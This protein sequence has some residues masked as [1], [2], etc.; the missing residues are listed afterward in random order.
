M[1]VPNLRGLDEAIEADAKEIAI[2]GSATE[3]FSHR[4]INCSIAESL[5]KFKPIV[6]RAIKEGIK[7][8]GYIS[9]VLGCPVEGEVLPEKVGDVAKALMDMGCYE[10]SL[11]DTIGIGTPTKVQRLLDI[12]LKDI[13]VN[14]IAGHFHDTYGQALANILTSL[15]Y[16]VSTFDCSVAGLGGCPFAGKG[17]SGNVATE[18]VLFMLNGMNIETGIDIN[19]LV[20]VG[21]FI[22][23]ELEKPSA[24]KAGRALL[25][26][27]KVKTNRISNHG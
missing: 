21:E 5:Q 26:L 10:I 17:A 7:I 16:G 2:F 6:D 13:Q 25:S 14:Q 12:M 3:G 22:C 23:N 24:S 20:A 19:K 11:G 27:S 8:R 4:N 1:L 9:V 18:D 15:E